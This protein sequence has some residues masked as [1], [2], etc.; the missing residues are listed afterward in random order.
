MK[1]FTAVWATWALIG[2]A[3]WAVVG[4][5]AYHFISKFW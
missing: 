4:F 3:F 5:V 1:T 2:I